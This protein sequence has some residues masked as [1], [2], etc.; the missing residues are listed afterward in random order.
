MI[1]EK[2]TKRAVDVRRKRT[3]VKTIQTERILCNRKEP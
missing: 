3:E 1:S 2:E